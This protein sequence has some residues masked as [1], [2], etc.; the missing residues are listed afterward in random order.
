MIIDS[1]FVTAVRIEPEDVDRG[2]IAWMPE[3]RQDIYDN[4]VRYFI[5]LMEPGRREMEFLFRAVTPGTY[6]LP[7]ASA[8]CMYEPEVFGRTS[9]AIAIIGEAASK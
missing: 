7:P 9:G 2:E 1:R 3:M 8:E 5:D 4:E 6:P